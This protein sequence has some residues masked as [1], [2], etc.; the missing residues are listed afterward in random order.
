MQFNKLKIH[1]NVLIPLGQKGGALNQRTRR[2]FAG[3]QSGG[4][5]SILL[6]D[7]RGTS[8]PLVNALANQLNAVH[9]TPKSKAKKPKI[10]KLKI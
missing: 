8:E 3:K 5:A 10:F 1:R 6:G 4:E 9:I 2:R 7:Y